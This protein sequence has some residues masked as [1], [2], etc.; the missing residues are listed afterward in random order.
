MQFNVV[1]LTESIGWPDGK[2]FIPR[3]LPPLVNKLAIWCLCQL[4]KISKMQSIEIL[5]REPLSG[6]SVGEYE[7]FQ[8]SWGK[9]RIPHRSLKRAVM[10]TF[11]EV[12]LEHDQDFR[13]QP[14]YKV[15]HRENASRAPRFSRLCC[16]NFWRVYK[17]LSNGERLLSR[18]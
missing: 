4:Q 16:L 7:I 11:F 8:V 2:F 3:Q 1:D 15:L 12:C 17:K 6:R 10:F 18:I 13:F 5:L 14:Q 9:S